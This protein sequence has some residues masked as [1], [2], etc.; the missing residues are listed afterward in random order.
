MSL[1]EQ[2]YVLIDK[3]P[4]ES[5]RV[6]IQ[7]MKCM[8][9]DDKKNATE[10]SKPSGGISPKMKAYLRMQELRKQTAKYEVSEAQREEA[11]DKKYG[12]FA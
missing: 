11:M 3:L 1:Q 8:L 2:A 12:A 9:P 6:V 4:E 10:T 5:I 7:V